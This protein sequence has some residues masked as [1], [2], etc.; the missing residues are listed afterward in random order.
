MIPHSSAG[1]QQWGHPMRALHGGPGRVDLAQMAG[2]YDP[3]SASSQQ[4][5]SQS[6][7]QSQPQPQPA[8]RQTPVVDLTAGGFESHDREPPPKRPKLD[9]SSGSNLGDAGSTMNS[10]ETRSTPGSAGSRPPLSWRGRPIWSFQ[11][12]MS[13]ISSSES[14]GDGATGPKPSSPPPFPAQ[15]WISAPAEHQHG[16]D[17][18]SRDTSPVKKVSTTPYRIETPSVAP[19]LKGDKV[20][21]FAPWTG[22]HPEDVLNEQTAK[23][24]YFDRTQVSQNESNT[25]RPA[26]YAQLKHRAGLQM[27]S[28]VFTAALEKR[29]NHNIVHAPSTF[30]P[31]PRVTL[32]DNKREAWLRD[33]A[34]SAVPL[35]R[36]SRTIP[37]GIRGKVL[38]DQCLGKWIPVARAVWLAK[39]VGANEIRAFKRKGTSGALAVGLEAKWVRDWTTN[40]QQFVEGVFSSPK[41]ND[42]KAKMT[43][44][45]GLTARLF[46]ENLLDHDH[47]LEWFLSSFEAASIATVPVW[48]LMLGI[49]WNSIMRYRRRGRRLAELLLEKLRQATVAKLDP[50]QPLVDRLSHFVNK[51]VHEHTSSMILPNSWDT[52]KHQVSSCLNLSNKVDRAL[53]QSIAERNARVQRPRHP[54]QAAQRS[55]HQRIIHLLDSIRSAHDITATSA[56]CLDAVDDRAVLVSRLLE[57]LATPFRH[58]MCRVYVGVRLLRKWKSFGVDV[59]EHILAFLTHIGKDKKLNM[60][61]V[62]HAISELVRSQT[63]SVGRYFQWLMAKGVTSH[64]LGENQL[65]TDCPSDIRLIAHVPV[66]RL[67]DHVGNLR[68]T[69]MAR[70]GFSVSDEGNMVTNLKVFISHR[71]PK[72]FRPTMLLKTSLSSLPLD[73][74]W[75]VKAE[76]G[77]WLRRGVAEHTRASN[78]PT[79]GAMLP[80]DFSHSVSALTS[81]EFYNVRDVL[82]TFGDISMLAD[83]LNYASSSDDSTVLASVADTTN[84]HFD[85]LSVIGA[86]TDL[87]RKLA[88]AYAGIKRFGMPSLDIMFSLIELGLRIPNELNT[89]AILRQDLS[90]MENKSVVAASSPVSDHIPDSFGEADPLFREKLDQLLL[91]GNVMDEPT[92]DTL[93]KTLIKHLESGEGKTNFSANDTCR[94]LAQL[95]SFQPKHFDGILARWVCAHLRSSDRAVLL[96]ALPP[97]IGVGCVTIRSFLS[98]AKRLSYSP[99]S[100]PNAA[101]LPADL[102]GLLVSSTEEGRYL[103]L[104]SYRFQLAQQEFISKNPEEALGI[105]CDAAAILKPGDHKPPLRH[106]NLETAM[107]TLLRELLVRNPEC[108]SQNFMQKIVNKSSAAM[109]VFQQALD[110]LLGVDVQKESGSVFSEVEKLASTAD[111][112]SLPFCQLKLQVVFHADSAHRDRTSIVDAMFRTVVADSRANKLHWVELIALMSPDAVRQIRERAEKEFFAI[113]L[114]EEPVNMQ[115][116]DSL[117]AAKLYL[118][119]I[120]E[121]GSSI[122]DSGMPSIAPVLVEKMDTLLH[123]IITLQSSLNNSGDNRNAL[124]PGQERC[125]FER[126]LAFW[127]SALLRMV[128]IHRASFMQPSPTLKIGSSHEQSRLLISIFCIAL[129]RLPGDVLRSF[130]G[131]DYFPRQGPSED[132]RPCPGILLQT[133][134]LDVAASL[135]D[136]FPDEIRHQCA[137]FLKEKCP[138]FVPL[139][140]DSRFLYL[141]GPM[142]DAHPSAILQSASAPSPAAS[143]STPTPTSANFPAAGVA[144]QPPASGLY[145]GLPENSNC[146]ANR[147][148]LQNRGRIVGPY[149]IR[150]WELL[151]DAAPFVGVNDTAVNL[152]YFDARRVRV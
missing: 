60:D 140:N 86:T 67:P 138:P 109:G 117:E 128:I 20:A 28:S 57:W 3:P 146:M 38:L 148:R 124:P 9:V 24:G 123:R 31:P 40:V 5:V 129:S 61:H 66:G 125:T 46:F 25:A 141:L 13:E 6:Q 137:R 106:I 116:K 152:G 142:S 102:V 64:G 12:V 97:L 131:A 111:D 35:R 127:F 115:S 76:I 130:P 77:Q 110:L 113:P 98:L 52:Y 21:C 126:S 14:R 22:N 29:Q 58:G 73:L 107:V 4:S 101:E 72:I 68:R 53:F 87:F 19:I 95:R 47:F 143:A 100:I 151:E 2:Q 15:P 49:Y 82:E 132:Y 10:V 54:K 48:L 70:S 85:S 88:D 43:Y 8:V 23:Q 120:E 105:V 104:V 16:V 149:P 119:I 27:L 32:T 84:C 39:C 1:G 139:Q 33:L 36:L 103:D 150:P 42:W 63:F 96:R 17:S 144:P 112:F 55:P 75:A 7:S 108:T 135:I 83:V 51:L 81:E 65:E 90:R 134:A 37:H 80:G 26:L 74:S 122:P 18:I 133:H 56:S 79:L 34:N 11:A 121:L 62:Y 92:L 44:A 45:V 50:L 69:L 91:S 30:K 93:F 94:Y 147:L 145:A 136:I 89:V 118:S 78:T 99:H 41:S 114:F 59:D 71:I